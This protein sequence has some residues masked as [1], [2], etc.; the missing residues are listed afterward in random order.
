MVVHMQITQKKEADASVDGDMPIQQTNNIK[1]K[2]K[3]KKK[4]KKPDAYLNRRIKW[5]D[6]SGRYYSVRSIQSRN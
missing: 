5:T 6:K 1:K 4:Q 2:K 3:A